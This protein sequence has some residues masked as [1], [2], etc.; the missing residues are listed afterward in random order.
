M[1]RIIEL[2]KGNY[3]Q[4]HTQKILIEKIMLS[5]ITDP[6]MPFFPRLHSTGTLC[7]SPSRRIS[8]V[9]VCA[10][11]LSV[12]QHFFKAQM[13]LTGFHKMCVC[14]RVLQRVS[15][16]H[17]VFVSVYVIENWGYAR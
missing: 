8:C 17:Q 10:C 7:S 1:E 3:N 11:V 16:F 14:V 9:C 6:Q 4:F 15:M 12:G 13:S 5:Q 2:S